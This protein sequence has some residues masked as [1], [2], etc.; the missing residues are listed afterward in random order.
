MQSAKEIYIPYGKEWEEE[1]MKLKK[2]ELVSMIRKI[3][4]GTTDHKAAGINTIES[5]QVYV[6][7]CINDFVSGVSDKEE[8]LENMGTYT[9]RLM[10]LFWEQSKKA[11]RNNP[12]YLNEE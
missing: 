2:S 3:K 10:N 9:I 7:G 4:T 5:A 1:L 11:I 8:F 6:E 12:E